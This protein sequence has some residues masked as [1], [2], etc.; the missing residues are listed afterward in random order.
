MTRALEPQGQSTFNVREMAFD[1]AVGSV[2]GM[3]GAKAAGVVSAQL[4]H[5]QATAFGMR[6]AA[7]GGGSGSFSASHGAAGIEAKIQQVRSRAET[8]ST[9]VG[10]KVGNTA[11]P[12]AR[13]ANEKKRE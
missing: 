1:A 10:A 7:R 6:R 5:L 9:V 12:I 3:L 2:S 11:A 4:P 13:A 8:V